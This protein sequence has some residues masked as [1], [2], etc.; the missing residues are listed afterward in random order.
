[1][2]ETGFKPRFVLNRH[3]MTWQAVSA[4][5]PAMDAERDIFSPLLCHSQEPSRTRVHVIRRAAQAGAAQT[6]CK[7]D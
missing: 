3:P 7:G 4:G 2:P 6:Q 1:M 5:T